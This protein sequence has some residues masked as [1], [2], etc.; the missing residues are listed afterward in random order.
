MPADKLTEL[1]EY[2]RAEGRVCP[3]PQEWHAPWEMLP[4]KQRI[5]DGWEP[6]LPLILG[7]WWDT[8]AL[9]KMIRLEEHIR[10]AEKHGGLDQ[11]DAYLRR[12]QQ[13][14]WFI[15]K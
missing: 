1:L 13:D 6:P 2:V 10:Y 12:L 11:V 5:G 4:D 3:N 15:I 9:F 8:P 14:E 7:A